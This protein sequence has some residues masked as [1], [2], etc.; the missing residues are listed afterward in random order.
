MFAVWG[1]AMSMSA[2]GLGCRV[3]AIDI[4]DGYG[5]QLRRGAVLFV[6]VSLAQRWP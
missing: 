6:P 3:G 2:S 5:R 1:R 4:M